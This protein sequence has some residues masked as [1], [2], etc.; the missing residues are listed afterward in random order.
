[1][2][3]SLVTGL[4]EAFVVDT[5]VAIKWY[6]PEPGAAAAIALLH[7]GYRPYAPDHIAAELGN[8]MWKKARRSELTPSEAA[9]IADQFATACPV[10]LRPVLTLLRPAVEIATRFDRTVYDA[11]YLAVAISEGVP[12]VTADQRLHNALTSTS[13]APYIRLLAAI[14]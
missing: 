13:L 3:G 14:P 1:V 10:T 5:S 8:V 6:V 4:P 11:L 7:G 12:F 9:T 2:A